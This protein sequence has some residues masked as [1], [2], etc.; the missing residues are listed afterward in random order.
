MQNPVNPVKSCT[1]PVWIFIINKYNDRAKNSSTEPSLRI[2]PIIR[3]HRTQVGLTLSLA[4]QGEHVWLKARQLPMK[5]GWWDAPFALRD[6][7]EPISMTW[8]VALSAFMGAP[9]P[10]SSFIIYPHTWL[11]FP[12]GSSPIYYYTGTTSNYHSATTVHQLKPAPLSHHFHLV[13]S[14]RQTATTCFTP[15][16]TFLLSRNT[17]IQ[18]I[19][20]APRTQQW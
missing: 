8:E 7:T 20:M 19:K 18:P 14:T 13:A 9:W 15:Q 4:R 2:S 1:Y 16:P 10:S 11:P 17:L 6:L 5:T 12:V 3:G